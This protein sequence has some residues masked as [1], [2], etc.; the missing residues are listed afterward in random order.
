VPSGEDAP[1]DA[2]RSRHL[3]HPRS[4]RH[5]RTAGGRA[6]HR[7]QGRVEVAGDAQRLRSW[8]GGA[9]LPVRITEGEPEL[10]AVG[11]GERELR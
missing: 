1:T 7:G 3:R 10:L 5:R 6:R 11:I 9:A 2:D 8:L 4:R